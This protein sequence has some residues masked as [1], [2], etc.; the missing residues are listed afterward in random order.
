MSKLAQVCRNG[1]SKDNDDIESHY[2]FKGES[3]YP[4]SQNPSRQILTQYLTQVKMTN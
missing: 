1:K 2:L 3:S 4:L